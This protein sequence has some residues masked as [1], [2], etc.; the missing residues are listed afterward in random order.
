MLYR[1]CQNWRIHFVS[2]FCFLRCKIVQK[3]LRVCKLVV[4]SSLLGRIDKR[5]MYVGCQHLN[6]YISKNFKRPQ[7]RL[8]LTSH[9]TTFNMFHLHPHHLRW[10]RQQKHEHKQPFKKQALR[11]QYSKLQDLRSIAEPLT[12]YS[13]NCNCI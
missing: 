10:C 6:H 13:G 3:V 4:K 8:N 11:I 1:E 9:R 12:T 2:F 5:T 7:T